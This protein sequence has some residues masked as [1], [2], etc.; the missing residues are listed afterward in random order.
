LSVGREGL[1]S[2]NGARG[3]DTLYLVFSVV[4]HRWLWGVLKVMFENGQTCL[5]LDITFGLACSRA[6]R[7]DVRTLPWVPPPLLTL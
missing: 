3:D 6:G 7:R 5:K 2:S 1:D 4:A